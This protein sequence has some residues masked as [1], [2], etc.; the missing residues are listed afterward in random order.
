MEIRR[1]ALRLVNLACPSTRQTINVTHQSLLN[2]LNEK[3][4]TSVNRDVRIKC[5]A[6]ESRHSPLPLVPN[7]IPPN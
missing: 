7:T 4:L 2:T 1:R 5:L 6:M 3:L